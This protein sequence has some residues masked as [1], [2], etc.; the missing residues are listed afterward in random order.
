MLMFNFI[1]P[2]CCYKKGFADPFRVAYNAKTAD[3]SVLR[4]LAVDRYRLLFFGRMSQKIIA[5][6]WRKNKR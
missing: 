6:T 3:S 1:E 2:I 5:E 4:I